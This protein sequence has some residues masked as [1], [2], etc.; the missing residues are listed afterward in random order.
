MMAAAEIIRW[1]GTLSPQTDVGIDEGGLA[2]VVPD[3]GPDS[4]AYLEVGGMS[5]DSED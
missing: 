5:D 2:L 1:L 3:N 4:G